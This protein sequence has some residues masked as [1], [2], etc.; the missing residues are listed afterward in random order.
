MTDIFDR[1]TELEELERRV[2]LQA[3]TNRAGLVGKTAADS[4]TE[5]ADCEEPIPEQRRVAIPGCQ[6]CVE[7][8][9]QREKA[10]YER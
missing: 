5:C 8:Q 4:A 7:C 3:Q 1:A 9:A 6:R 2:A 10:F